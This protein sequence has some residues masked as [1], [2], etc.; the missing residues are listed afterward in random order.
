MIHMKKMRLVT[1][2][3]PVCSNIVIAANLKVPRESQIVILASHALAIVSLSLI[4]LLMT[5]LTACSPTSQENQALEDFATAFRAANQAKSLSQMLKLYAT[6]G[7][8][9][10]QLT[11]LRGALRSELGLPIESIQF[12]KYT[13]NT[14][15]LIDYTYE[16]ISYGPSLQPKIS[17]QVQYS[18]DDRFMSRF[19]LGQTDVGSWRIICAK[20]TEPTMNTKNL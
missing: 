4:A 5:V 6:T 7:A 9:E 12:H 17:M 16:G 3:M 13:N 8:D 15:A 19:T 14:D 18:T 10:K 20:P 2:I 1:A 11:A